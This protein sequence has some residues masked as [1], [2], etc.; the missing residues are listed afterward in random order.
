MTAVPGR[1]AG[2]ELVFYSQ[3][4]RRTWFRP[5]VRQH[6]S[7]AGRRVPPSLNLG[8]GSS[9]GRLIKRAGY[10]SCWTGLGTACSIPMKPPG[11]RQPHR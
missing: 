9:A 2:L 6:R 5:T 1:F 4:T 10:C 3:G 7:P 11:R 8:P